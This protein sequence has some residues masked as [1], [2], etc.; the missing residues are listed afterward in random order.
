MPPVMMPAI[1]PARWPHVRARRGFTRQ[2]HTP[3]KMHQVPRRRAR[4]AEGLQGR[5]K[6]RLRCHEAF[7]RLRRRAVGSR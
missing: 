5:F 3:Y 4:A 2:A 1:R 7:F 6:G